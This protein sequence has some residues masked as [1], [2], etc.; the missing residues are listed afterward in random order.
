M[1]PSRADRESLSRS[2]A[3]NKSYVDPTAGSDEEGSDEG[4]VLPLQTSRKGNTG[5][6]R[7]RVSHTA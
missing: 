2:A 4:E 5:T 7:K 3:R 1:T 6:K